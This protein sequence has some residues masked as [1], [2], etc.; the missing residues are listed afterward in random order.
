MLLLYQVSAVYTSVTKD[1]IAGMCV[2]V[3]V[4][5][6]ICMYLHVMA[7]STLLLYDVTFFRSFVTLSNYITLPDDVR[8]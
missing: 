2:C 4:C 6:Y 8:L 1:V 7:L 5:M 3:Y